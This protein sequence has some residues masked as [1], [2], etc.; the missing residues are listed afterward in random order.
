MSTTVTSAR[1]KR[2][3]L[4]GG[5]PTDGLVAHFESAMEAVTAVENDREALDH[6]I[7]G[8][9][10]VR[11]F[12]V[13]LEEHIADRVRRL[14]DQ[15]IPALRQE[16]RDIDAALCARKC[17]ISTRRSAPGRHAS[18]MPEQPQLSDFFAHANLASIA[19]AINRPRGY[20]WRLAHGRPLW[21]DGAIAPLAEALRVPL[22]ALAPAIVAGRQAARRR[23]SARR[24]EAA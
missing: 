19:R 9:R 23:A 6:A 13:R 12:A 17:A 10:H 14:S 20:V 2:P 1:A 24:S 18:S 8:L 5:R 7:A 11:S 3:N 22:S 15:V 4:D 21:D 16:M